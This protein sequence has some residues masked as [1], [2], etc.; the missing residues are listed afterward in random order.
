M[1]LRHRTPA[2]SFL[3]L[4]ALLASPAPIQ[5]Q[6]IPF[7]VLNDAPHPVFGQPVS[8][9]V[10]LMATANPIYDL[11]PFQLVAV[12]AGGVS[13]RV[14]VK[15]LAR[16]GGDRSDLTR[17]LK[18]VLVS[19]LADVPANGTSTYTLS[20]G[21]S[22]PGSVT[23][24]DAPASVTVGT[25][26]GTSFVIDKYGFSLFKQANVE[27]IPIVNTTEG[28]LRLLDATGATMPVQVTS[29][30]IEEAG[31]IRA[32]ICQKG[33]VGPLKWTCRW[34]FHSG[35][36]DVTV[37]FRLENPAAYGLFNNAPQ[38]TVYFDSLELTLPVATSNGTLTGTQTT[39]ALGS[40]NYRLA[41]DF[42]W[43]DSHDLLSDFMF[44]ETIGS[45]VVGSGGRYPG[46]IDLGS[47]VGGVTVAVDRFWQNYPKAFSVKA[48]RLHVGLW[49]SWGHGP[50]FNGIY[51]TP[52][53]AD[54]IDP[55]AI[56][57]Y[58][59]EGGRWKTTRMVFDFHRF[60]RTPADV[61][62]V[63]SLVEKPIAGRPS[64][65]W[66]KSTFAFGIP[67]IEKRAWGNTASDRYERTTDLVHDDQAADYVQSYGG[68]IGLPAFR[69]Q[70]GTYGGRQFFGWENYGDIP[71]ACG[72]SSLH[73]DW[74]MG[75]LLNWYRGGSY[76]FFDAGRDMAWHRRDYDQNHST[77]PGESWR[78]AQFY[79]KG[80]WHGNYKP[81]EESHTWI[82]GVLMHYVMTGEE[83]SREA[84]LEM[85]DFCLRH[86]PRYWAGWWGARIPGWTIDNLVDA[87]NYLGVDACLIE[88]KAGIANFELL[89]QAGGGHGYVLNHG[90]PVPGSPGTIKPWHHNIFFNAAARYTVLTGDPSHV[91]LLWR[92]RDWFIQHGLVPAS[93][94]PSGLRLPGV[95]ANWSP[96]GYTDGESVILM[97]PLMESLS[98]SAILFTNP[99]DANL[100]SGLFELLTRFSQKP[101]ASV[102]DVDNPT[103]WSHVSM[104]M[105]MF[106]TTESKAM[107]RM[108]RWGITTL[109]MRALFQGSY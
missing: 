70:G 94:Q 3:L 75:V 99:A 34:Y 2:L 107:G 96:E 69:N 40:G 71:W 16:W 76:G 9:G 58:R 37:D 77:D 81:G 98:W 84:G 27:G 43:L 65:T 13:H 25:G 35:R 95:W 12:D 85:M 90:L 92:M 42:Q 44:E 86:S 21:P 31:P 83:A 61:A 19:F 87:Y 73:Y 100:A 38:G 102:V 52:T 47:S 15:P 106:P 55:M 108:L 56:G 4:L 20:G 14:Q 39:R 67:F 91:A 82:H 26:P 48:G 23:L 7:E 8:F 30:T 6:A 79:E 17:P 60:G 88:A 59:F 24:Q 36:D 1:P 66:T 80:W 89:E 63:A 109:T 54:P 78:G 28:S 22:A 18:W 101:T 57:N 53:S 45:Q 46:A 11:T 32:V 103:D 72:E 41:Q 5:G 97:W 105:S 10:P 49:P 68:R 51:G 29:T 74:V 93:V 33:D 50:E 64:P 104:H 62:R